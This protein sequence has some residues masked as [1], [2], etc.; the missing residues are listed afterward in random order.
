MQLYYTYYSVTCFLKHNLSSEPLQLK[1]TESNYNSLYQSGFN[2]K[3][4]TSKR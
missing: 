4:I 3:S 2:K 1:N